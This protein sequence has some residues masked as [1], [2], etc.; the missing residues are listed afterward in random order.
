MKPDRV[1]VALQS[2][3]ATVA[4]VLVTVVVAHGI[5]DAA[6][7]A[8]AAPKAI[9]M[10]AALLVLGF[11][12][13]FLPRGDA[14][15]TTVPVAFAAAVMLPPVVA[16]GV[17]LLSRCATVALRPRGHTLW[18][19]VEQIGRRAIL[20]SATY[21]LLGTRLASFSSPDSSLVDLGII[22]AAAVVF[23]VLDA[24]IEQMHASVRFRAPILALLVGAV[25]LQGWML[26]AEVSTA[27][28]IVVAFPA[29]GYWGLLLTVGLLLVMRQ[30]FALLLEVRA[31]YTSTVEVLARSLEAYDPERRG[32]AERVARMTGEAG[33]TIGLQGKRL[34]SLTYAALFHD[35]DRLG[36]DTLDEQP[37]HNSAEVL[38]SVGFL[39]GA[40]PILR[41]LDTAAEDAA[42]LDENDLIGA[43]LVARFSAFD[44]DLNSGLPESEYLSNAIGSRLYSSTR[45]AVDR[46]VDRVEREARAGSLPEGGLADVMA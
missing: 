29:L 12:N 21:L 43:Y 36:S 4:V 8:D 11:F 22:A 33:R 37:E 18:T 14:V 28:L 6:A 1:F 15:D 16:A 9:A 35:V 20:I 31:S 38:A 39:S 7:I 44:S 42:S 25:R 27:A 45:I 19:A 40:L 23:I 10:G 13:V 24:L 5:P 17:V 34:E 46:A 30:S 3:V 2:V 32:H 26:A 41:I